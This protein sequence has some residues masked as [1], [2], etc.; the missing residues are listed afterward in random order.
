MMV[1]PS[2][3][4]AV[5]ALFFLSQS[6]SA[7][8]DKQANIPREVVHSTICTTSGAAL[9]SAPPVIAPGATDGPFDAPVP[10][11]TN[12][13]IPFLRG[14]NLGGWL[15]LESWMDDIFTGQFAD[16]MDQWTFDSVS[17]ANI[18][19]EEHWSSFFTEADIKTIAAT[20]INALRIPI[21]YWAYNN[22]GTPYIKG[23]DPYLELAIAWARNSNMKVWI[24]CHGSPGSQ[25]GFESSGRAGAVEWQDPE[26][27]KRSISVLETM[28]AKYGAMEYADVVVGLELTNEPI[29]WYPNNFAV[30][31]AWAQEAYE[32]VKAKVPNKNLVIVMHDGFRGPLAWTST[33]KTLDKV[34]DKPTFGVDTHM[35]QVY[36][37]YDNQLTQEQHIEK[38]CGWA[39]ELR[40]ANYVMPTYVGEWSSETNICVDTDGA[41]TPGTSCSTRGC[42]CQS[43]HFST[44]KIV[45][46]EQVR[47]Y[48]EA[49]LDVFEENTSGYFMWAA[50]G[51]GGWGFL[52][53]IRNGAIPN[54]V[55]TRKYPRQC[56]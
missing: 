22:T 43:A 42:Q 51:P 38:T 55:T 36:G 5:L 8:H 23:A 6:V 25:N 21:G 1:V 53:G 29:S 3:S 16:A 32:A 7:T 45:M 10:D 20:G 54:P 30:T 49:Q 18:A 37:E 39:S 14:V 15:V 27:M 44:W 24:D 4:K 34:H 56:K 13:T 11:T 31:M 46:V 17:G 50:K 19:L 28:A 9:P 47:R 48:V 40:S 41:T 2:L 33:A 26:N 12:T 52:N 35:Y